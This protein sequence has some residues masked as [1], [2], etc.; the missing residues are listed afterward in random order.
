VGVVVGRIGA[1]AHEFFHADGNRGVPAIV[2][3]VRDAGDS[4]VLT[5][6]IFLK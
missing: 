5:P 3:K 4:H 6:R 2:V 1:D